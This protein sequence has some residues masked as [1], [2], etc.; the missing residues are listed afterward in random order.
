MPD[1]FFATE[2]LGIH[3]D[4]KDPLF[5]SLKTLILSG[6]RFDTFEEAYFNAFNMSNLRT[7]QLRNCIASQELLGAISRQTI[8]LNLKSLELTIDGTCYHQFPCSVASAARSIA[9]FLNCFQ[10]LEDLFLLLPLYLEWDV[11]ASGIMNHR[12][13]LKRFVVH[14]RVIINDDGDDDI[15]PQ[16]IQ[17]CDGRILW[18]PF[19]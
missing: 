19:K 2:V 4:H 18:Y 13:T 16:G 12:S 6:Y 17:V 15:F 5:P 3:Q 7:L 11:I 8:T 10:G 14:E 1:N 9:D